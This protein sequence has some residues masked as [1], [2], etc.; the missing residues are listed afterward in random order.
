MGGVGSVIDKLAS[1]GD[2]TGVLWTALYMALLIVVV[3]K[4]L[5]SNLLRRVRSRYVVE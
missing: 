3:N 1:S 5:W 2:A 4:A